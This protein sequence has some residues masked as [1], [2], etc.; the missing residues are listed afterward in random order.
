VFLLLLL[1][2]SSSFISL[3][4]DSIQGVISI[5]LYLLWLDLCL[6]YGLF[7]RQY[8]GLLRKMYIVLLQDE[9]LW[10]HLSVPLDLWYHLVIVL[11]C[12]FFCMHDLSIGDRGVLMSPTPIVLGSICCF[13]FFSVCLMKLGTLTLDSYKLTIIISSWCIYPLISMNWPSLSLLTNLSL[14]SNLSDITIA[15]PASFQGY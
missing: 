7:W 8:H 15:T 14:T 4:S 5:F 2:L 10:R 12:W 13:K 3:S 1:L 9:K 11:F 6:K